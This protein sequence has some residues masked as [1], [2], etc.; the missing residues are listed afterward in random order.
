MES[1]DTGREKKNI[2][3]NSNQTDTVAQQ[4]KPEL[5]S[6]KSQN[7]RRLYYQLN[8]EIREY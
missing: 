7:E 6:P 1:E 3:R 2:L 4:F 5:A 8:Q